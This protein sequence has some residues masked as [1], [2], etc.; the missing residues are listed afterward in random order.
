MPFGLTNVPVTYIRLV[1]NILRSFLD[2]FYIVYLD[3]II[4]Y[5]KTR[6]E[7]VEYVRKV[8]EALNKVGLRIKP[9]KT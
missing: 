4:V 3:D 9:S 7:Y 5:S 8:L 1:N 6:E 2:I